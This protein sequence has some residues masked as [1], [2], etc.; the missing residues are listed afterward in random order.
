MRTATSED[1]P[2][3]QLIEDFHCGGLGPAETSQAHELLEQDPA[4]RD[5][6]CGLRSFD[7]LFAYA[8]GLS[9]STLRPEPDTF[10]RL[11]RDSRSYAALKQV[12]EGLRIAS[13]RRA[14]WN[15]G[16]SSRSRGPGRRGWGLGRAG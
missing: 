4:L 16:S 2:L 1:D 7:R 13:P 14:G 3:L 5:Y 12:A 9:D 6:L 8:L 11:T 10:S 15:S